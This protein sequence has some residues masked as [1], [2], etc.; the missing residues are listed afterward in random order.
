MLQYTVLKQSFGG[1]GES[2]NFVFEQDQ[3]RSWDNGVRRLSAISERL[4]GVEVIEGDAL[5]ILP[6]LD[7]P[8]TL[9]FLDPPYV[10]S[11]RS[12]TAMYRFEL[13]DQGHR[14]LCGVIRRLAD[15]VVLCGYPN[16][17]YGE[18]L[19]DWRRVSR[20]SYIFVQNRPGPRSRKTEAMWMNF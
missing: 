10:Q 11:A 5:A 2:F 15:K 9:F 3:Q 8:D 20:E 6:S 17:I 14:D 13:S 19:G 7:G 18:L 1:Q 12:A 16:P 4:D